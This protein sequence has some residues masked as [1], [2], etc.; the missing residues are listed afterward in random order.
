M[1]INR[2]HQRADKV[3]EEF[4]EIIG[5]SVCN[6]ISDTHFQD[7]TL[8]VRGLISDELLAA[9]ELIEKVA[10]HLRSESDIDELGL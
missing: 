1:M 9:A 2:H 4:K 8:L 5:E 3:V 7:L 6:Q 10:Q